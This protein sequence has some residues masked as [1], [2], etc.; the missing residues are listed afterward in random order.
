MSVAHST[1]SNGTPRSFPIVVVSPLEREDDVTLS[2]RTES[3][4]DM[5]QERDNTVAFVKVLLL[6]QSCEERSDH[7]FTAFMI[8]CW[9]QSEA[10][11]DFHSHVP[12]PSVF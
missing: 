3:E 11:E 9:S 1:V 2:R 6:M 7:L 10:K 12:T 8:C 4:P 5:A